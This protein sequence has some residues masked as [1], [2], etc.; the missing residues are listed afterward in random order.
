MVVSVDT[1]IMHLAAA[2]GV[3]VIGLHG[4][5][6]SKRWGPIG[7]NADAIDSPDPG[8]GYLYLGF[9]VPAVPPPC[10]EAISYETVLD[11]CLKKLDDA[12]SDRLQVTA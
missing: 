4:P 1:G 3:P 5:T 8:A 2:L 9:E 6:S 12:A 10:M 11:E 7:R